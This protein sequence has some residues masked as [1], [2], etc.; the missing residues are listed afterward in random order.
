MNRQ[1]KRGIGY[2]D[3]DWNPVVGCTR[4]CPWCWAR[5]QAK[6]QKHNCQKCYDFTPHLHPERLDEP[7][8]TRKP[9]VIGV[10]FMGD[11]FDA[12]LPDSVR[13]ECFGV[14]DTAHWHTFVLLTKQ[15]L[16]AMHYFGFSTND[17]G[18][19]KWKVREMRDGGFVLPLSNLVLGVS[20]ED[21]ASADLRI[22]ELLACPAATRIVSIEPMRGPVLLR[23]AW[24]GYT[25]TTGKFRTNP[26]TGRRQVAFGLNPTAARLDGVILGGQTGPAAL[27]MHPDWVR[28][29]RDDCA[30]A[31]V[32]FYFKGWGE[33]LPIATPRVHAGS[34]KILHA[35]G[36]LESATWSD[37][38]AS[39]GEAWA[40]E[41]VGRKAA[42][43]MLDGRTHDELAWPRSRAPARRDTLQGGE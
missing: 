9:S 33:W 42:G 32:P 27:P 20:V 43:R 14:M 41:R 28:K 3:D 37:V 29:V 35:D 23:A 31:G 16:G 11:L 10:G 18:A 8:R 34:T 25:R 26:K 17:A 39:R 6:R 7:L 24:F 19:R 22:P 12:A 21:Q 4:G 30:A 2:L 36:R 5:R 13:D 1:G 15:A 40:V 38:M